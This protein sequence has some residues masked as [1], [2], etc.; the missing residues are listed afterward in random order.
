ME[1]FK[2]KSENSDKGFHYTLSEAQLDAYKNW[3]DEEKLNW[4]WETNKLI[5]GAQTTSER[6]RMN[7]IKYKLVFT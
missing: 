4:I 2:I 1:E 3:T 6:K 7:L 5:L